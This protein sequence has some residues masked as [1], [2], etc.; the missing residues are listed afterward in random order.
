MFWRRYRIQ[1]KNVSISGTNGT[2]EATGYIATKDRVYADKGAKLADIDVT[3]NKISNGGATLALNG[4]AGVAGLIN[5][6]GASVFLMNDST[7]INGVVGIDKNG[8]ITNVAAG[9]ISADSTDAVNGSQLNAVATE[10][11]KQAQ[12]GCKWQ[13][14]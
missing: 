5:G 14:H 12:Q 4:E 3:G 6:K 8:K 13:Q 2:V 10:A 1:D 7:V 9:K 11:S